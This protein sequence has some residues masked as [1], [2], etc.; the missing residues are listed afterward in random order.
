[1]N[2]KTFDKIVS[3][4]QEVVDIPPQT[5]GPFTSLYKQITSKLKVMPWPLLFVVSVVV[6]LGIFFVFG[7]ATLFLVELIQRGF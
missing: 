4:W 3:R 2:D 6:V 5:V 1:M 7:P